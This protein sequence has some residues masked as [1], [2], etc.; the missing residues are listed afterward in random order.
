LLA[1]I[2]PFIKNEQPEIRQR[3]L[4]PSTATAQQGVGMKPHTLVR[5]A[6]VALM[7]VGASVAVE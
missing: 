1:D 2:H 4:G 6:L 5:I 3:D 7:L